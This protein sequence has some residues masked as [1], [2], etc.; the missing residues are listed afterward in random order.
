MVWSSAA[1]EDVDAI[2]TYISRDSSAY[3]A[4]IVQKII[5]VTSSLSNFPFSGRVVPEL[6]ENTVREKFAYSYR[7]IYRIEDNTVTIAAVVHGK[8]SLDQIDTD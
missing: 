8:R 7:I 2:A 1:L 5:D 3:A 6:N 4:A